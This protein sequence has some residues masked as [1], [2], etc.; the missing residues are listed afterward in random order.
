MKH[1]SP[2]EIAAQRRLMLKCWAMLTLPS[3]E[4]G[5]ILL[6]AS[7]PTV[8]ELIARARKRAAEHAAAGTCPSCGEALPPG[9]VKARRAKRKSRK[10]RPPLTATKGASR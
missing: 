10:P 6:S 9:A 7:P 1:L 5:A 3:D 8:A 4:L 2:A